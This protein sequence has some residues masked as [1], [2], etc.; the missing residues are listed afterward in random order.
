MM[1]MTM[2][3]L[4]NSPLYRMCTEQGLLEPNNMQDDEYNAIFELSKS[5]FIKIVAYLHTNYQR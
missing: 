2:I 1:M 4:V 5:H 3:V